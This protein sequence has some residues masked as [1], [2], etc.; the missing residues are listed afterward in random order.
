MNYIEFRNEKG[1][2]L[3]IGDNSD[4]SLINITGINPP[5]ANI[6]TSR[7]ASFDGTKFISSFVNQRNIVMTLQINGDVEANRLNLYDIFKIKRKGTLY[8]RS[9]L[10]NV[11]IEAYVELI[12]SPP[13][14]FPVKALVSLISPKAYFEALNTKRQNITS[15]DGHLEFPLELSPGFV[16]GTLET[17]QIVNVINS[18]DIPIGMMIIYRATGEIENPRLVNTQTLDF[19]ELNTSMQAGD[20]ITINTEVGQ[21]RIELDR[22]GVIT[23]LFNTLVVGSKFL[24]LEEGDNLLFGS[25]ESGVNALIIEVR[26]KEKYSGV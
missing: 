14:E 1:Q 13:M 18:G 20:V 17:S 21:K 4:Y 24:Q 9:D 7:I 22:G 2:R 6:N 23:N 25:A 10:I 19:I 3:I 11:Q 15:I 26:Y 8:Y 12:E 5:K 16:F